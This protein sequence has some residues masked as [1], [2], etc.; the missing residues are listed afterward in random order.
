MTNNVEFML[1]DMYV[2]YGY[3]TNFSSVKSPAAGQQWNKCSEL[4]GFQC[5]YT[6]FYE[7]I[8]KTSK[9]APD[10]WGGVPNI[11]GSILV[12]TRY[13]RWYYHWSSTYFDVVY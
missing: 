4:L 6:V 1:Q 13:L 10:I 12:C 7:I 11:W 3:V 8:R 5:L 9:Y 2:F